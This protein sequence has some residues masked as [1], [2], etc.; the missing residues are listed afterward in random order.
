MDKHARL[1]EL[2]NKRK[3]EHCTSYQCIG[4]YHQGAY[5]CNFVSPYTKSARNVNADVFIML[6]DWCSD[7][8][9]SRPLN[10]D[11]VKFWLLPKLA[12]NTNLI[13]LLRSVFRLEL[14]DCY[15]TNLFPF[16]KPKNMSGEIPD[17]VLVAAARE[18]GL[19]QIRVIEPRLVICLG[20]Q[21]FNAMQTACGRKSS[22]DITSALGAFFEFSKSAIW[23]QAHTGYWG[24]LTRERIGKGQVLRDWHG[25]KATA[26]PSACP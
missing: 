25:M 8:R 12:T 4:S 5:E 21:T 9:L 17:E 24:Q 16:V 18:F 20:L 15:A 14:R 26:F 10:Q 6:Q 1:N 13:N 11:L 19:P 3:K 23:C 2:A 7:K 22:S